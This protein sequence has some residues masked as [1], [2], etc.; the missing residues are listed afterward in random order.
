MLD[1]IQ[2]IDIINIITEI[3]ISSE[4]I[5]IFYNF[6]I[7][8]WH[9]GRL[10]IAACALDLAGLKKLSRISRALDLFWENTN[11]PAW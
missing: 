5:N 6:C 2:I 7:T 3:G 8:T 1:L 9:C 4:N 10:Q 11:S